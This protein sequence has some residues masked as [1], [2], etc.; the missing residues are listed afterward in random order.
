MSLDDIIKAGKKTRG[1]G[2]GRGRGRG[3]TRGGGGPTRRGRGYNTRSS[4]RGETPYS[5]VS[6]LDVCVLLVLARG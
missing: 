4:T 1:T 5:R 3:A 2:R 6:I